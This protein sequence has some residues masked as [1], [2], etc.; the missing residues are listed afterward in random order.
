MNL[1]NTFRFTLCAGVWLLAALA[2][3]AGEIRVTDDRGV[4][5]TLPASPQRIVS[6]LP[7]LTET[8]CE[9]GQ[10]HRLVGVDRYSNHPASVRALPKTG[11]G[12][13][14]NIEAIVALKPDLVLAAT[15]SRGVERLEGFGLKVLALEP[16][17]TAA[18][19]RVM[20]V[21]GEVLAVPDAPRI[22]TRIEAG[23]S[24][25]AQ[26]LPPRAKPLRVYYE[27]SNGG[28]AAGP[29]SFIGELMGRL[30]VQNIVGP[31]LGPFPRINPEYVVRADPDLILIGARNVQGMAQR[32]GWGGMRALREQ[33]VCV[34]TA[35]ESD[36]LV[37]PGP[38]MAEAARLLARCI[39]DKG[40]RP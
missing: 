27:V 3:H 34:F 21:L 37:R 40:F 18:A 23:V 19:R 29:Q 39:Q 26:S 13:D 17:N 32:P 11:G 25:A 22:W 6:L 2:S 14:P 38:R 33:R 30:G 12:V 1:L 35:D 7:S 28:Y 8:V 20:G 24:A 10:C 36:V 5:V 16:R 15:S 4:A 9:L 31:E